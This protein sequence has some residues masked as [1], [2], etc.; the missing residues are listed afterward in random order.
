[1]PST[2]RTSPAGRSSGEAEQRD[3]PVDVHQEQRFCSIC[4]HL[5]SD[6][7]Y[8]SSRLSPL[9]SRAPLGRQARK[10]ARPVAEASGPPLGPGA[11]ILITHDAPTRHPPG[12]RV[13]LRDEPRLPLQ[14]PGRCDGAAVD[15]RHPLRSARLALSSKWFAIGMVVAT[16]RGA[17]T[18][19]RWR[20][21]RS[22]VVQVVLVRRRRAARRD[23]RAALRLRGRAPPVGG[24]AFTALGLVLLGVTLPRDRR[25][26]LAASRSP[27]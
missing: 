10:P 14:V 25:R 1:M 24:V 21:R 6:H 2:V 16:A 15:I 7:R 18:S 22:R 27:A 20:W 4:R 12:A 26:A 5:S 9:P 23:G 8:A 19:P 17:S 13:R 3:D 11:A